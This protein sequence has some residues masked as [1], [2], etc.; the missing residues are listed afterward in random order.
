MKFKLSRYVHF[1]K[2]ED[3]LPNAFYLYATRSG[4][5]IEIENKYFEDVQHGN[6]DKLPSP[7]L[8]ALVLSEAVVTEEEDELNAVLTLN[9][10]NVKDADRKFLSFTIQPTANCQLGCHYCG[11]QHVKKVSSTDTNKVIYDRIISKAE[12]LKDTLKTLSISWYGGEPITGL[13][14]IEELSELLI[15]YC[16][17]NNI[18]YDATM[19]T[20]ALALKPSLF[21]RLVEKHKITTY[22]I[23]IDGTAAFHDQRRML[24]NGGPSFD[25]IFNNVKEIVHSDFFKKHEPNIGIRCNVDGQ[26]KEN[27]FELVDMLF[28]HDI[29]NKVNFNL[30]PIHDWGDNGASKINGI[31]KE[32]FAQF[33]IDIYMKLHE[34]GVL[35]KSGLIPLKKHNVCMVVNEHSEVYDAYGNVSTCWEIPYTPFYD[36]TE[37][38]AGNLHKTPQLDSSKVLMRDWYDEIPTNDTWCKGCRFLPVCGGSCPK[39]WRRGTP[40]CPSFK[41]NIDERLFLN[42]LMNIEEAGVTEAAELVS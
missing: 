5:A 36:N 28:E 4:A 6:W 40:A 25:I 3:V 20:N 26:N 34:Y 14:A 41:F 13:S 8:Q 15:T 35:R 38:Y 11:Q 42:K 39:H 1:S 10:A 16:E 7:V 12:S 30:A 19:I 23:T 2:D 33:E 32:D 21:N 29:L 22:Q 27:V 17:K 24:K 18:A 31:S 37:F 9:K